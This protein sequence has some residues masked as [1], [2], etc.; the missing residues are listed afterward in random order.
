[1]NV[2][3]LLFVLHN[4]TFVT[5]YLV[6]TVG[7]LM[8]NILLVKPGILSKG[9]TSDYAESDYILHVMQKNSDVDEL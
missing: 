6:L 7:C 9:E 1:M 4:L 2:S 5:A 8:L 3:F